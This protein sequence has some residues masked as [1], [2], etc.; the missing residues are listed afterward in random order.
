VIRWGMM[1]GKPVVVHPFGS[2]QRKVIQALIG[3]DIMFVLFCQ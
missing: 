1:L 2:P 3:K